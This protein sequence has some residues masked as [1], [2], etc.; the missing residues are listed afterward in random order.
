MRIK[1]VMTGILFHVCDSDSVVVVELAINSMNMVEVMIM[2]MIRLSTIMVGLYSST[3]VIHPIW[4]I[5]E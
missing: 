5:D 2:Y 3:A 1:M 4:A